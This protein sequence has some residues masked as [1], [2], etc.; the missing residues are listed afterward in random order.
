VWS[1]AETDTVMTETFV[2][3]IELLDPITVW[4]QPA[5]LRRIVGRSA[6]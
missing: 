3:T 2:R 4:L 5:T 6:V 1:S